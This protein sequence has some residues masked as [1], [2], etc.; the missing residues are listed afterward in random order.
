MVVRWCPA[1]A[2][3]LCVAACGDDSVVPPDQGTSTCASD[4]ECDDGA[5]CNGMERCAPES[6]SADRNG[7]VPPTA[8]PCVECDE[9]NDVCLGCDVNPDADS[10]GADAVG[11]GGDDCDDSDPNRFP[12]NTEVCDPEGRD[13]DCD[14]ETLAGAEGDADGDGFI[15]ASCCNGDDCGDD[16]DDARIS[17]NPGAAEICN[18]LDDDC[19]G[20]IDEEVLVTFYRDLDGDLFGVDDMTTLACSAPPGYSFAGGDCDDADPARNPGNAEN[21]DTPIDDDCSG[22]ANDGCACSGSDTRPCAGAQGVCAT[23]SE[24]CSGG[25]FGSC[26]ISPS[27][28]VCGDMLDQ[29]CNGTT[30]DEIEVGILA[31]VGGA[32]A[33]GDLEVTPATL[34]GQPTCTLAGV[35]MFPS[36]HVARMNARV[37]AGAYYDDVVE[38]GYGE[39]SFAPWLTI[40]CP[41]TADFRPRAGFAVVIVED[42]SGPLI[43]TYSDF[44]RWDT[45]APRARD[46]VAVEWTYQTPFGSTDDVILIRRLTGDTGDSPILA[47]CPVPA[48]LRVEAGAGL[49]EPAL[50]V[51]YRPANDYTGATEELS[52]SLDDDSFSCVTSDPRLPDWAAGQALRVGIT[53]SNAD[54]PG[55][56]VGATVRWLPGS[57]TSSLAPVEMAG[58]CP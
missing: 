53:G 20:T 34:D 5:F 2:F 9:E 41:S 4:A 15:D 14:P 43:G 37:S 23:G 35:G 18:L 45:G 30:D 7:C 6:A 1:F 46:G 29:N 11:C 22:T 28:E 44:T 39:L 47:T 10:D 17:V 48:A 57:G 16:C 13:E 24:T 52:V 54:V 3:V 42:G 27:T 21:C 55:S 19:D 49:I 8:A 12:G 56:F 40:N 38:L 33:C 31:Q 58:S 36:V 32:S 26:S 25:T 51:R 50:S